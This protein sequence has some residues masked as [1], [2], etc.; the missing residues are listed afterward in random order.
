MS[1]SRP[2]SNLLVEGLSLAGTP[3]FE[4]IATPE[5]GPFDCV[6]ETEGG[7]VR[8][9]LR[10]QLEQVRT[11]LAV[12]Q[13]ENTA[14]AN[15]AAPSPEPVSDA[16]LDD[17]AAA[18]AAA[19]GATQPLLRA[20]ANRETLQRVGRVAEAYGNPG[21][22]DRHQCGDRRAVACWNKPTAASACRP[23]SSAFR[24]RIPC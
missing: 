5:F 4:V 2:G 11:I 23:R 22:R 1:P 10:E 9:G 18:D 20:L 12:A 17:I 3:T 13:Q 16:L 19:A 14:E 6:I 24:V 7:V 8:A 15:A 21:A